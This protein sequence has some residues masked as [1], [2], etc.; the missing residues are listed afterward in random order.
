MPLAS[1]ISSIPHLAAFEQMAEQAFASIDKTVVLAYLIDTVPADALPYLAEQLDVLGYKGWLFAETEAE[2][3]DLLKKA[4]TLHRKKGTPFA[5]KEALRAVNP[6]YGEIQIIKAP[7]VNYDG[8]ENYDGNIDYA[9][10]FWANFIVRIHVPDTYV[11]TGDDRELAERIIEEYKNERSQLILLEFWRT[12]SL[13]VTYE[14]AAIID[15]E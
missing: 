2:K 7:G 5:V 14:P 9:G 6:Q 3:R 13:L 4:I 15:V 11:V 10:G 8:E 12:G 1:A